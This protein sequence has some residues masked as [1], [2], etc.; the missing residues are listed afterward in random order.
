MKKTQLLI[1]IFIYINCFGQSKATL[2]KDIDSLVNSYLI[3]NDLPSAA[4]GIVHGENVVYQKRIIRGNNEPKKNDYSIYNIASVAKPFVA[5]A[6]LILEEEGKV[7]L[8]S[9]INTY[10]P[11]FKLNSKFTKDITI[12]HLLTHT[13]GLPP[14]STKTD[15]DYIKIDTTDN[16]LLNHINSLSKLKLKSKPGKKYSYSN[17]GYEILGHI[18]ATVSGM[19]FDEFMETRLFQPLQLTRT[20]YILSD[21][22]TNEIAQPHSGHP[23]RI[24]EKF[25]Y[26]RAF[27]PSGNLFTSIEDINKWMLFNLNDGQFD[28]FKPIP[29]EKFT[30]LT[31]PKVQTE[32]DGFVGLSWFIDKN[33]IVHD[34]L[35]LGYT[36]LMLFFK[37]Q[38]IGITVLINHQDANCNELLNLITKYIQY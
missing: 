35:D 12:E 16:A 11:E 38:K 20:S 37:K 36:A 29:L 14:T 9:S 27:S 33:L 2:T 13:S 28:N 34:G 19:S 30:L 31:T 22:Q 10:L 5:T 17:V 18:I 3:D 8:K 1:L 6:I 24:T 32:E 7:D 21:F 26:N 15:Y 23:N 4:V 25:P